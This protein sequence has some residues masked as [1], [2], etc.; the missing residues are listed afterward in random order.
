[1]DDEFAKNMHRVFDEVEKGQGAAVKD[2]YREV[3]QEFVNKTLYYLME[4]PAGCLP[5]GK[6][7]QTM[8]NVAFASIHKG[9]KL[10]Y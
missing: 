8:V 3:L 5:M 6:I 9:K 1:M 7:M 4:Q 10:Q 2:E